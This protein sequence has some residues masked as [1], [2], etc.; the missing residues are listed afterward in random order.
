MGAVMGLICEC[1]EEL[2]R[3][4]FVKFMAVSSGC[5]YVPSSVFSDQAISHSMHLKVRVDDGGDRGGG[6]VG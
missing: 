2:S 3:K 6:W 1:E 4:P 5:Q